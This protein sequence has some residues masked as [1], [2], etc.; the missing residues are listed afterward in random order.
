MRILY[1]FLA[2]G[3]TA[4]LTSGCHFY[5]QPCPAIAQASVV[6]L[7]VERSYVPSVKSIHLKACQDG[8]CKEA[9]LELMPG[10]SSV[11]QGCT[12]DG[13]DDSCSATS[14]PNGTLVGMLM[15]D[16]LTESPID[17]SL[18]GTSPNGA[19]LPQRSLTFT[20]TSEYPFG[21]QC[22]KFLGASLI[23]DADGLRH[24]GL[25]QSIEPDSPAS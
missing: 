5:E 1:G 7:T 24:T 4:V 17:A 16:V 6:S 3:A 10:T 20:P 8:V 25:N 15:L 13:P 19:P 14:V 18:T 2:L 9:D 23:L 11:D 22:G 12:G 21:Q